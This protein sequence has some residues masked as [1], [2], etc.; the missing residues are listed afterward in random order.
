MIDELD[1]GV[2]ILQLE[3]Q[4]SGRHLPLGD[5]AELGWHVRPFKHGLFFGFSGTKQAALSR[6][7][8]DSKLTFDSFA[9]LRERLTSKQYSASFNAYALQTR[10]SQ[11]FLPFGL[12]SWFG[13]THFYN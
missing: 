2:S 6:R 3:K 10:S 9:L 1:L 4:T 11:H 13:Y 7:Y 8:Y 5:P 12:H